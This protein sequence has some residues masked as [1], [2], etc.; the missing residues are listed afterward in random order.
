MNTM[1]K[2]TGGTMTLAR[3]LLVAFLFLGTAMSAQA[4]GNL[5]PPSTPKNFQVTL[6]T[7]SAF[8]YWSAEEG[9]GA[10]QFTLLDNP[11]QSVVVDGT[12]DHA[13]IPG[14]IDASVSHRFSV[15]ASNF[16]AQS[17]PAYFTYTPQVL[18]QVSVP[19]TGVNQTTYTIT[20]VVSITTY[21]GGPGQAYRI[22]PQS[23][24]Q[25]AV[26]MDPRWSA[27]GY[28]VNATIDLVGHGV[29]PCFAT[30]DSRVSPTTS[31]TF[32]TSLSP[33]DV[34]SCVMQLTQ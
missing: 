1:I 17:E 3:T 10:Y 11:A 34:V 5:P 20:G 4:F 12:A 15:T 6:S 23:T 7:G 30:S 2:L 21:Q 13:V 26:T 24:T 8:G 9:V 16:R 28:R 33:A 32:T 22:S 25:G 19:F 29:V 27:G 18:T 14:P 31:V